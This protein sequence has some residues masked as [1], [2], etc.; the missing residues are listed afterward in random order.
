MLVT[1]FPVTIVD[2]VYNPYLKRTYYTS[3]NASYNF[4]KDLWA[5]QNMFLRFFA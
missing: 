1:V 5:L 4:T 2:R 3:F